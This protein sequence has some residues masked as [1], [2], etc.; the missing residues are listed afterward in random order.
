M[1]QWAQ[2]LER[3]WG[4]GLRRAW[5]AAVRLSIRQ[6]GVLCVSSPRRASKTVF[7][8]LSWRERGWD[9]SGMWGY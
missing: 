8:R 9:M 2:A 3:G 6:S 5:R 1:A 4:H 7:V